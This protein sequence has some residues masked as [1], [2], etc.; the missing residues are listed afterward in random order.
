[1]VDGIGS[2]EFVVV[3]IESRKFQLVVSPRLQVLEPSVQDDVASP[4]SSYT[5]FVNFEPTRTRDSI[6]RQLTGDQRGGKDLHF[7]ED[8]C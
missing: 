2:H 7:S 8:D 3:G 4:T 6:A 5:N 1:M